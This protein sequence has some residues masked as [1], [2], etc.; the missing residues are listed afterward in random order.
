MTK[1]GEG[2]GKNGRNCNMCSIESL[3]GHSAL[4]LSSTF[5]THL[6]ARMLTVT[7]KIWHMS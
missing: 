1:Q 6:I 3:T 2:E 5:N 4:S 7:Y